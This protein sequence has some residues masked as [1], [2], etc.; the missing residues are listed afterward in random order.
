MKDDRVRLTPHKSK[1]IA[2]IRLA[3]VIESFVYSNNSDPTITPKFEQTI[4]DKYNPQSPVLK[5]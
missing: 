3:I 2:K 1:K 4:I 5:S